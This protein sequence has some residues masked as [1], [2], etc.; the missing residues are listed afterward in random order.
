[1]TWYLLGYVALIVV[2]SV[3]AIAIGDWLARGWRQ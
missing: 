3:P 1:M 2:A